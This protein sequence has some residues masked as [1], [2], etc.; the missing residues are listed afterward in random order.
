MSCYNAIYLKMST[1]RK[2]KRSAQECRKLL[3]P[4]YDHLT[5]DQIIQ[6]RDFLH[7]IAHIHV[8]HFLE[9]KSKQQS[10]KSRQKAE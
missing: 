3:G 2:S 5:D 10:E 7:Q 1:Y 9:T 6:I 8:E 4:K